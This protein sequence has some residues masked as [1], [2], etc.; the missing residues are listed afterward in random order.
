MAR[1]FDSPWKDALDLYL[2]AFLGLFF[3][4]IHAAIDWSKGYESLDKELREIIREAEMGPTVADKLFRVH[5]RDGEDAW[6]LIHIEVQVQ[7]DA[8]FGRRMF[9]YSYRIIDRYNRDVVS[10]AL[11]GDTEPNWRPQHYERIRFGTGPSIRFRPIKLIDWVDR[12]EE[13]DRNPSPIAAVILAHLQSLLTYGKIGLRYNAKKH[14][15]RGLGDRG[16]A[17]RDV[18]ELYRLV[19]WFLE[20]PKELDGPLRSELYQYELEKKMPYITSFERL[21]REE[22]KRE[23]LLESLAISLEARFGE[24]GTAF[25]QELQAVSDIDTLRKIQRNI[26]VASN[27]IDDLRA[28]LNQN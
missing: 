14:L 8:D 23:G 11:L 2:E 24:M 20:L 21:A 6:L 7:P 3:P 1:E 27:S 15:L 9:T 28:L 17:D 22:G 12:M 25:A 16:L 19:D 4:D 18:R 13:L 26:V 5:L 10:L